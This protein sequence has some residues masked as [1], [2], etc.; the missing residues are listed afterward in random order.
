MRGRKVA[1]KS[2]LPNL[3]SFTSGGE[4]DFSYIWGIVLSPVTQGN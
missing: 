3:T 1:G 2:Y 4:T